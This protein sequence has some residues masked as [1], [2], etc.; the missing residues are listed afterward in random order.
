MN[1]KK[2]TDTENAEYHESEDIKLHIWPRFKAFLR[3]KPC[4]EMPFTTPIITKNK[5]LKEF[6]SNYARILLTGPR[7]LF[8]TYLIWICFQ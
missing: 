7:V 5:L 8:D 3:S 4:E 1:R 6:F 2:K